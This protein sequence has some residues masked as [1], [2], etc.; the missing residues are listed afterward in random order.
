MKD[1]IS[2]AFSK[3]LAGTIESVGGAKAVF[4]EPVMLNGEQIVPVAR[5]V[6]SLSA[7]AEGSGGGNAGVTGALANLAKGSGGGNAEAGIRVVV[8]PVGYLKSSPGGP[9]YVAF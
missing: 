4:G 7:A 9:V 2:D 6:I 8:E 5:I 1:L 3:K